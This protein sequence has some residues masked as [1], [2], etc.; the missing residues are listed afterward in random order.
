MTPGI[1]HSRG[2][3]IVR[4]LGLRAAVWGGIAVL[5]FVIFG[6]VRPLLFSPRASPDR[7][8]AR[9]GGSF[10]PHQSLPKEFGWPHLRGP[11]YDGSSTETELADRWPAEGPPLL[12]RREL[13][14]GYSA[15]IAVGDRIYTQTQSL[16]AQ[17]VVCLEADTGRTIWEQRYDWPY[18]AAGMYPGPRATP[19]WRDGRIY[20]AGPQGAVGCLDAADGRSRW[21]LNVVEKFEGRG[22]DFGYSCSPL[23]EDGLVI[24]PVGGKGASVVALRA[25]D[26]SVAWAS[27]DEPASYCSALPFSF[28]GRRCVAAFLENAL[29][30]LDLHSGRLLWQRRFS[31]GYNEHA[32]FPLYREPYLMIANPF[33]GGAELFR[34]KSSLAEAQLERAAPPPTPRDGNPGG[35]LH[36]DSA[37]DVKS[38]WSSRE[39]SNDV[40]SSVLVDGFV[41]GFDLRDIQTKPHRPSRGKFKCLELATGKIRWAS[42]RP[43]HAGLLTADGKL[44]LLNDSGEIVLVRRS[45]DRYEE[46]G[47]AA[48]FPG[49]ICWTAPTL[50]RGRL[51]LR[52]PTRAACVFVGTARSPG[53]DMLPPGRPAAS[54]PRPWRIDWNGLLGGERECPFDPP[55]F[56]ELAASYAVALLGVFLP[57]GLAAFTAFGLA[58]LCRFPRSEFLGQTVFWTACLVLGVFAAGIINRRQ[59]AFVFTWPVCLL[60]AQQL[61]LT[62]LFYQKRHPERKRLSFLSLAAGLF[63]VAVCLTYFHACRQLG[64]ALQWSFLLGFAPSFPLA[65]PAAY[66]FARRP[67]LLREIPLAAAAYTLFF[68]SAGG[69]LLWKGFH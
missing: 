23:V 49:E 2:R 9:S 66:W 60:T 51:F 13:G 40:A 21:S 6:D 56:P 65:L 10:Q 37:L 52:S 11:N 54:A 62:A 55:D 61:A 57:A 19:T 15:F 68:W 22:H 26:G 36:H 31:R 53:A 8:P 42:D 16:Y 38:V 5:V 69:Y 64:L 7:I 39:F 30:L 45:P 24:L 47:R 28:Q 59:T 17:S 34:L 41:Y 63:F 18:D 43:G 50:S 29:A 46:L 33:R 25:D 1:L 67:R 14:R 20:F 32:A 4:G 35:A 12:W 48:I 3:S 58:R 44:I 27:G